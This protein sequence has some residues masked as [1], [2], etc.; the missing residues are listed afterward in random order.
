MDLL[1]LAG[2]VVY[3]LGSPQR[4]QREE[5]VQL[6]ASLEQ[7]NEVPDTMSERDDEASDTMSERD[8]E[9]SD[10]MSKRDNEAPVTMSKP[11]DEAPNN[12]PE[13]IT[14]T[15]PEKKTHSLEDWLAPVPEAAWHH[16]IRRM[17]Q[18]PTGEGLLGSAEF[19]TWFAE[20]GATLLCTGMPGTGKTMLASAVIDYLQE[21][22][23]QDASVGVAF[24][25]CSAGDHEFRKPV[26]LLWSLLRQFVQKSPRVLP[27]IL[28]LFYECYKLQKPPR[29]A[30]EDVSKA[31]QIMIRE[32]SRAFVVIDALDE[33]HWENDEL[34][35]FLSVIL[36][37]QAQTGLNLLV[38]SRRAFD[39]Q[40][41]FQGFLSLTIRASDNDI[42]LYLQNHMARLPPF[43]QRNP[44]LLDN[45]KDDIVQASNGV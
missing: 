36:A 32:Y 13:S 37:L 38:T 23:R 25:Y 10:P 11:D 44:H 18:E 43:V 12:M 24:L 15:P 28:Q 8:D 42:R 6:P 20:H 27:E 16:H 30:I 26:N 4:A 5:T 29:L 34:H 39:T 35:T 9:I 7:D 31:M 19:Q 17:R 21:K 22:H 45:I 40:S 3:A 2:A 14:H 41:G 1:L 33:C